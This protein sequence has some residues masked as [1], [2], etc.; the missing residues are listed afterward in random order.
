MFAGNHKLDN[1]IVFVYA[2]KFQ[3]DGA[4]AD[5]CKVEDIFMWRNCKNGN[6]CYRVKNLLGVVYI[7]VSTCQKIANAV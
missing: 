2:N 4:I 3:I 7:V 5:V 1:M 6:F